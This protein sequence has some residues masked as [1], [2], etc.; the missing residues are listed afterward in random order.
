MSQVPLETAVTDHPLRKPRGLKSAPRELMNYMIQHKADLMPELSE[1][2]ARNGNK[3]AGTWSEVFGSDERADEIFMGYYAGRFVGQVAKAG[4]AELNL[5]MFVNAFLVIPGLAPGQYPSGGPV[6]RLIDVYYAAAPAVDVL[7]PNAY[8]LGFKGTC[9]L[10]DRGGNP[11]LIPETAPVAGNLFWAVG[12]HATLGWSPFGAVETLKP[13]GQLGTPTKSSL[14]R[15]QT[16]QNGRPKEKWTRSSQSRQRIR[17]RCRSVDTKS[18]HIGM[19]EQVL[20]PGVPDADETNLRAKA[21]RHFQ[22]RIRAGAE[23]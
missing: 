6:H 21:G 17:N 7:S 15:C 19:Q 18:V 11:L 22:H 23:E 8:A 5:P 10:Y 20:T 16:L 13:N 9:A 2:W 14:R 12:H 1:I 3:S 4:K